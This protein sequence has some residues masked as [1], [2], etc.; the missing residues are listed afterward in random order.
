MVPIEAEGVL[1]PRAGAPA[2]PTL[3]GRL[4]GRDEDIAGI[5]GALELSRLV[6]L[7]GAPGIGK[8][9]LAL[10]VGQRR[11]EAA[12][13]VELAPVADPALVV[14]TLAGALSVSE[15]PGQRVI[16]AVVATYRQR[17]LLLVLDNCEHL[18]RQCA[19]MVGELLAECP[20]IR[21]LASSRE[22]LGLDGE[23]EWR[24][25]PL[26]VPDHTADA[27][28]DAL[29][30]YPAVALFVERAAEAQPGFALNAFLAA[31][32]AEICR[33]LEG[34]P[35]AIEL[36]AARVGTLTPS[37]I[38]RRLEDRLTLLS[39]RSRGG[40]PR[41]RTVTAALDW[42]HALLS[43]PERALLRRLSVFAGRF[44][45]DA[46]EAVCAG[47]EV[48]PPGVSQLLARLVS[49]SLLASDY[50]SG[51]GGQARYRLLETIRAYAAEKLEE[52][53]EGAELRTA[54]AQFYL[55]LAE[56]AEAEL[57][58]PRQVS[59]LERL[60]AERA[61]LRA[62]LEWSL[63][64]GRAELALR[65]A[66][67]LVLFWR[68]RGHFT[69]GRDL[70]T[71]VLSASDGQP[72]VLRARALWGVGFLTLMAGDPKTAI[73]WLDESL[74]AAR[75]LGDRQVAARALLILANA[76]Q[77]YED[78]NVPAI[79]DESAGLAREAGDA[80]C[81]AHAL[82]VAGFECARHYELRGAR[83]KFE[84]CI[85]VSRETG[86]MQGLRFGL[87][88]LGEVGI[89]QGDYREAQSLL[90][91]AVQVTRAL[92]EHYDTAMA[93]AFLAELAF[94]RGE[95]ARARELCEEA[96]ALF[97]QAAP[98][99]ARLGLLVFQARVAHAEGDRG[100]ARRLLEEV[101][102]LA[103]G[104][105]LLQALGELAVDEGEPG[106]GRRLFEQALDLGRAQ[107]RQGSTAQALHS[108]GQ[109]ARAGAD[110]KRAAALHDE[111]LDIRRRIGALPGL[112]ESL[113]AIAGLAA[114]AGHHRQAARLFGAANALRDRGGFVS[115]P[116][117]RARYD[118][119]MALVRRSLPSHELKSALAEGHELSL[120][121]A[122][123][124]AKSVPLGTRPVDG[125]LSL[126]KREQEVAALVADGLTNP[127]IAE[128]LVVSRETVKTHLSNIF[129]KL[130]IAGRWELAREVRNGADRR[131]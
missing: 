101:A 66:G 5:A 46:A 54:H 47:E 17:R 42:S 106:E 81:L 114:D 35:L 102:P 21:V 111:A 12:A 124:E 119:D 97:P 51:P 99:D 110:P 14:G 63:S 20:E 83:R 60:E 55:A 125:W 91:E 89:T 34:I 11:S 15:S 75:E 32:V 117:D 7:T 122:V 73:D 82:G 123:D 116:W 45:L 115:A 58:G 13:L 30:A 94:A 38:A 50:G 103:H 19:A 6:T 118:D 96:L 113:E 92:H 85:A 25:P 93:S 39:N 112:S 28:P 44:E 59:W 76:K 27:H 108:L 79:L 4:M 48:D 1:A 72:P 41:H 128:R 10:A 68:V 31:D 126:T 43:A 26:P 33:R 80:W 9:R 64:H 2:W 95:Y 131:R 127:E 23:Q 52:S 100:R 104:D 121:D 62:A 22:P 69:E 120:A 77:R 67:A 90:E 88:G 37:E 70:L 57:T 87:L 61:D 16:D 40:S 74:A 18:L 3:V 98:A 36:A 29:T 130:G 78:P 53:G 24:V 49:K 109:V 56:R 105:A 86:D 129:A 65:L 71:G 107:G 8:T 84:E